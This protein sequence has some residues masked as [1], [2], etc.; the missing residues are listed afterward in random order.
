M[1][2]GVYMKL[3]ENID[4]KL[5]LLRNSP[6]HK[7]YIDSMKEYFEGNKDIKI[8]SI[9]Y[10]TFKIF[11]E[12]GSR[13]EYD[14]YYWPKRKRLAC[15]AMLYLLFK[16]EKYLDEV[17]DMVWLI[18]GEVQW[19]LPAHLAGKKA[20]NYRNEIDL[21]AAETG[22][23]LAEIHY[24]LKDALPDNVK[25]LIIKEVSDRIFSGFE[26]RAF[27]WETTKNNWAAVCSCGV[28]LSYMF[29]APERFAMVKERL[30]SAM[31][32][33][34]E[35]YGDDGCCQEGV[36]YWNYG[37]GSY[38]YFSA[39]LYDFSDGEIDIR[40]SEKIDKIA[41]YIQN[42]MLR[43]GIPVSFSDAYRQLVFK[44]VDIISYIY[45]NY[46]DFSVPDYEIGDFSDSETRFFRLLREFLWWNPEIE[47][48]KSKL[49]MG[50]NYLPDAQWYINRKEKFSFAAKAGHNA[51]PHNHNDVGS[52]IFATDKGQILADI[53]SMEY[54]RDT[55]GEKRYTFLNNSSLGHNVP[56][57]GETTQ[58]PGKQFCGAVMSAN[59]NEFSLELQKAYGIENK[60]SRKF[61]IFDSGI[62][63]TDTFGNITEPITE[64][65]ITFIEPEIKDGK[66]HIADGVMEFC[67]E[68]KITSQ[69][70]INHYMAP[71]TVYIIE[72]PLQDNKFELSVKVV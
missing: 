2:P 54:T 46:K 26:T 34:L 41:T 49:K 55:F 8:H 15:A 51:E 22:A 58:L 66:I 53:G 7:E 9:D 47:N 38:I 30:L 64:R 32:Y 5:E 12:S 33:F 42:V 48:K 72:I 29:L 68:A 70:L 61:E 60:M 43:K 16:E 67:G 45:S 50:W 19:A 25:R 18:C 21:M 6:S 44:N 14:N 24:L 37:F 69:T 71:E 13:A 28:G 1:I 36:G 39:T 23:Q 3:Y 65:F 35:S 56:I 20:E 11:F 10:S 63:M 17:C 52:F 59:E 62:K 27:G 31:E 57:I 40:H 4:K